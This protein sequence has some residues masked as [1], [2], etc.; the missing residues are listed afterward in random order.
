MKYIITIICSMI[1]SIFALNEVR[2]KLCINCKF[3]RNSFNND[4]TVAD[5]RY[6]KCLLFPKLETD[7]DF[8]VTGIENID[9]YY[10]YIAR[11]YVD[12]C[13]VEGKLYKKTKREDFTL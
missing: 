10:A 3:F 9:Y 2:P 13:G 12:M 4:N 5:S 1:V 6:G 7:F 8:L 11:K